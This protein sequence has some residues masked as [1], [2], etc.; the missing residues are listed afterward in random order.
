[1]EPGSP[2]FPDA[3]WAEYI[4]EMYEYVFVLYAV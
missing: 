2:D 3:K 4:E 1:M